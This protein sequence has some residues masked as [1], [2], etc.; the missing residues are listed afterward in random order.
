M[1]QSLVDLKEPVNEALKRMGLCSYVLD[2]AEWDLLADLCRF[3]SFFDEL[4]VLVSSNYSGLSLIPLVK[5]AITSAVKPIHKEL[6][7]ITKLKKQIKKH[8]DQRF[9]ITGTVRLCTLLDPSTK[10]TLSI[11][12]DEV[13]DILKKAFED[14][15]V[16]EDGPIAGKASKQPDIADKAPDQTEPVSKKRKLLA[17]KCN[18][19]NEGLANEILRYLNYSPT[20]EEVDNPFLFWKNHCTEFGSLA[21]LAK[22]YLTICCSSVPVERMFSTTGIILNGKRS[23]LAPYKL[24]QLSFIHD[25]YKL[26]H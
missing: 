15:E 3:L 25:N 13:V 11:P 12:S 1:G 22:C 7:A 4:T 20:T 26:F 8:L 16:A 24:N 5:D 9:P 2:V 18:D 14:L 17:A 23:S 21:E 19:T 10:E 6:P